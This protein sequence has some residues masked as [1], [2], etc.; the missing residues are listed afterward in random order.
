MILTV[1]AIKM[2]QRCRKEYQFRHLD[3]IVKAYDDDIETLRFG[4][5]IHEALDALYTSG[6][7]AAKSIIES[8]A[9]NGSDAAKALGMI[10]GYTVE[11][12]QWVKED[13]FAIEV[14]QDVIFAGKVDGFRIDGENLILLEHKT[15]SQV[16]D[17]YLD[18]L[19]TDF[20]IHAYAWAMEKVHGKMVRTVIYDVLVKPTIIQAKGE[21]DAEFE[22][23]CEMLI[24]KS[25]SGKTTA[26]KKEP[27]SDEDY[28]ERCRQ[29]CIEKKAYHRS[30]IFLDRRFV[31]E[32]GQIVLRI[33]KEIQA[34]KV[35]GF[36]RN[37]DQCMSYSRRCS[38]WQLCSS[39]ESQI[40]RE[41]EYRHEL[42]HKELR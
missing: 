36:Y 10:D 23:R 30:S 2:F 1:S 31:Q 14:A 3:E 18:R 26:K 9:I 6:P 16:D 17:N 22:A 42:P 5:L 27:E 32:A 11:E 37:T 21:T 34:S 24:A 4:S 28:R 19:W 8:K 13:K 33:A 7:D 38:Y 25:K 41:N 39:H 15:A 29:W 20:Q 35:N 12:G 40:V